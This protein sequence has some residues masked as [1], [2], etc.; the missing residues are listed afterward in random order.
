MRFNAAYIYIYVYIHMCVCMYIYIS[1]YIYT[2][3]HTWVGHVVAYVA[4]SVGQVMAI[5]RHPSSSVVVRRVR[6]RVLM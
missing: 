3:A 6:R 4:T 5:R 2:H 1:I